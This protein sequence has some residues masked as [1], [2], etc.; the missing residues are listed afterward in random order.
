MGGGGREEK[1]IRVRIVSNNER[2]QTNKQPSSLHTHTNKN[3][4]NDKTTA[5]ATKIKQAQRRITNKDDKIK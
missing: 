1:G 4:T 5:N 3:K 2:K